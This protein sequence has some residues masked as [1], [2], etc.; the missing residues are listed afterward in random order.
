MISLPRWG[1]ELENPSAFLR[2]HGEPAAASPNLP[3]ECRGLLHC[4][5]LELGCQRSEGVG[6][7]KKGTQTKIWMSSSR[8][9]ALDDLHHKSVSLI[10]AVADTILYTAV[11]Q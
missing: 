8:R 11:S 1:G 9:T 3:V 7:K 5:L 4:F 6:R 2:L 10:V